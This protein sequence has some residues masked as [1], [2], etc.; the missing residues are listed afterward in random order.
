MSISIKA[1]GVALPSPTELTAGSEI[2][3]SANT[4]R[5]ASGLMVGDV[6][7]EKRTLTIRWGV[8]TM[9]ELALLREKLVSGFFPLT[10]TVDGD[11]VT[12]EGYRGALTHELLGTFGG[13]TYCRSAQ[14]S[15]IQR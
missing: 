5:T 4:G 8:L 6:V 7:A 3:W 14:V 15:V 2:I 12:V 10:L 9:G 13:V 1:G 11:S